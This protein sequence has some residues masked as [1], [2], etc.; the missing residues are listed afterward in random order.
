MHTVAVELDCYGNGGV[1][2]GLC[3]LN[4]Q[5]LNNNYEFAAQ[6]TTVYDN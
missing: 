1:G 6:N 2:R 3:Q 4:Y 5:L